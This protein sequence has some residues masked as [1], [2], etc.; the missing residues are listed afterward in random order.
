MKT[1]AYLLEQYN[2]LST[3]QQEIIIDLIDEL[4]NQSIDDNKLT[5]N[6]ENQLRTTSSNF[7]LDESGLVILINNKV[8]VLTSGLTGKKGDIGKVVKLNNKL[9][10]IKLDKNGSITHRL[11]KHLKYIPPS[12]DTK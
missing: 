8:E 12:R 7:H 4:N 5:R 2:K 6:K 10:R 9:I 3:N 1:T 11:P